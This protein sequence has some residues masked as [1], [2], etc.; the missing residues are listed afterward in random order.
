MQNRANILEEELLR[1]YQEPAIGVNY[2]N[3]YGEMNIKALVEKYRGLQPDEKD[4]MLE[5]VVSF[6][7]SPDLSSSYISVGVL[8]ALGKKSE[9]EQ[10][11]NAARG[12]ENSESIIGHFD[13]G[14]SMAEYFFTH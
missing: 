14:V 12:K 7:Q 3:S 10:A 4:Q 13:I 6:S 8:H 1:I 5:M 2:L 11:Y 9:V